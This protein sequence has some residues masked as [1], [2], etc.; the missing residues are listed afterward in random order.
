[1]P[2]YDKIHTMPL[3]VFVRFN[4]QSKS[5]TEPVKQTDYQII[6][7]F[8]LGEVVQVQRGVSDVVA[9]KGGGDE[10]RK[11]GSDPGMHQIQILKKLR[12]RLSG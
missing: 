8:S 4:F 6:K 7:T 2:E 9:F 5:F 12:E 11:H 1:M 10:V 3:G